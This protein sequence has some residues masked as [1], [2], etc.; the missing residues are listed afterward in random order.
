M[1]EIC[2]TKAIWKCRDEYRT[3]VHGGVIHQQRQRPELRLHPVQDQGFAA[4]TRKHLDHQGSP[5]RLTPD[6]RQRGHAQRA[7]PET[8]RPGRSWFLGCKV[9]GAF[10]K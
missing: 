1:I 5:Q 4:A 8:H 6:H 10:H 2:F 3:E 7:H 9:K